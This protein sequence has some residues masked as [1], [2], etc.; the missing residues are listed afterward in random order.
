MGDLDWKVKRDGQ[1][2]RVRA[3]KRG[4]TAGGNAGVNDLGTG[5]VYFLYL[6]LLGIVKQYKVAVLR[7]TE[8]GGLDVT[9]LRLLYQEV[10][11]KHADPKPRAQELR[12]LVLDG[13][14][15]HWTSRRQALDGEPDQN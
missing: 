15:D 7:E 6:G 9:Q 10:L 14:F 12:Q 8:L 4:D 11:P 1:V 5:I 2:Y 3:V 13:H